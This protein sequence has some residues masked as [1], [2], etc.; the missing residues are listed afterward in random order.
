ML[1][2]AGC[3]GAAAGDRDGAVLRIAAA[4]DLR[5]ALEEVLVAYREAHPEVGVRVSYGSSGTLLSQ[6]ENEAPFDVYLSA[7]VAYAERL[8][9][10]GLVAPDGVF[11]Y[12]V[13]RI[14]VWAPDA[15]PIDVERL[16]LR[17]LLHPSVRKVAI[18]NPEHAPYGRAAVAAMRS[19]GVYERVEDRLVLGENAAQAAQFVQTGAADIGVVP[20]SLAL[21][22][23]AGGR[24][25]EIPAS[26]HPPIVQGGAILRWASDLETARAF[27][28]VLL[29]PAGREALRRYGFEEPR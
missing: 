1:L 18:A 8:A 21:A 11:T 15:S 9:A 3:G 12:A 28:D 22:P 2:L 7:D 25:F 14:V 24:R 17:A 19:A 29:G 10:E 6:L 20:L 13:G 26:A 23:G 27:V 4:A 16:G 5:F